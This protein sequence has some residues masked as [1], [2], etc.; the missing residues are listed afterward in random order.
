M[1]RI[2]PALEWRGFQSEDSADGVFY[3][4]IAS[5]NPLRRHARMTARTPAF[6]SLR[7]DSTISALARGKGVLVSTPLATVTDSIPRTHDDR[8]HAHRSAPL[9]TTRAWRTGGANRALSGNHIIRKKRPREILRAL[10]ARKQVGI[11]HGIRPSPLKAFSLSS[12]VK[13]A[14]GTAFVKF[15][16][17]A[18]ARGYP[19]LYGGCGDRYSCLLSRDPMSGTSG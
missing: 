2:H 4:S 5:R 3:R 12:L 1:R 16:T 9:W 7:K 19:V 13:S 15:A 8:A 6:D 14:A 18:R 17:T 11:P 10:S